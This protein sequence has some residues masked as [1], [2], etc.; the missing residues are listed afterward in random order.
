M[1]PSSTPHV[2]L[3]AETELTCRGPGTTSTDCAASEQSTATKEVCPLTSCSLVPSSTTCASTAALSATEARPGSCAKASCIKARPTVACRRRPG[4]KVETG[5]SKQAICPHALRKCSRS[6]PLSSWAPAAS[7]AHTCTRSP[8]HSTP[9]AATDPGGPT[10]SAAGA[11]SSTVVPSHS[12]CVSAAF[13][14]RRARCNC[15]ITLPSS[16]SV[17][18]TNSAAPLPAAARPSTRWC[19]TLPPMPMV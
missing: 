6:G 15:L 5:K 12:A 18:A 17:P 16:R 19:E 11:N 10:V 8:Q 2:M 3:F 1:V 4:G 7:S 13:V 9:P 14:P